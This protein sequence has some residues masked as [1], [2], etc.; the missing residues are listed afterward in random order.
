MV[1]VKAEAYLKGYSLEAL[2]DL[3][4]VPLTTP[5]AQNGYYINDSLNRLFSLVD[6]GHQPQQYAFE[7]ENSVP[8]AGYD[9]YGFRVQ[10]LHSPLFNRQSTPLLSSVRFR[11]HVLQEVIQLLSLSKEKPG[12]RYQR[13]RISYAQLGINQLG[14]V[15]EALLS[16]SGFFASERLYEVKPADAR[17]ADET[18]QTY[19]IPE[20]ELGRYE[21][22]EFV[23]DSATMQRKTYEKGS[24][25]FRLAGRDRQ[26]SASYYTPEVLTQCVVKYSLKELLKDK[27]ADDILRLTICEPAMGSG[28]FINEALN[29]LADA[30]LE[31]KQAETGQ[32]IA[33]DDYRLERQKV[34]Y[35]LAVNN[36]YGV[37]LNPTAVRL[38]EVSL[39]L[40]IL[41]PEAPTPWLGARLSAGN[42]LVGA[43]RQ[44]Y[45]SEEVKSGAYASQAPAPCPLAPETPEERHAGRIRP[46]PAGT[47]YHWLLPDAGMAAFDKDKVIKDL[48]PKEVEGIKTWRKEFTRPFSAAEIRNLVAL[49]DRADEL[50]QQALDERSQ[51]LEKTRQPV[52]V[53]RQPQEPAPAKLSIDQ[54]QKEL[55][56][57]QRPNGPYARLKLV[58]DYWCALWFWPIPEAT[59]LPTRKQYMDDLANIFAAGD[60]SGFERP[61]EQL[62]LFETP[63]LKQTRFGDIKSFT[64]NDLIR[65]NLRL[66]K[67]YQVANKHFFHHWELIFP[68]V[69]AKRDGFNLILGNP[70]W[71]KL[72][73]D[74]SSVLADFEPVVAIRK[75]SASEVA[76][77]R[78]R[79]LSK[80]GVLGE[81]FIQFV[82]TVASMEFLNADANYALLKGM[83]SNSYKCFVCR[84][85][86][87]GSSNGV[88]GFLHPE[89]VYEDSKGGS[90]R[91]QIYRR[92]VAHYLFQNQ[93][94]LF[95]DIGDRVRYSINIYKSTPKNDIK[96]DHAVNL[97]HPTT[98]DACY[99]HDGYGETPGIKNISGNW[100]VRG[101]KNRIVNITESNLDLLS[102][103]FEES[104]MPKIHTRL[105]LIHSNEIMHV[106]KKFSQQTRHLT[107][108]SNNY[109]A[110]EMWH[111][112]GAQ[113]DGTI[114]RD[115]RIP[116]SLD[117]WIVSGPHIYVATPFSKSPNEGCTSKGDYQEIDLI[118]IPDDFL[119]RTV[120][121]PHCPREE[122]QRRVPNWKQGKVTENY[123]HLHRY[124][125]SQAGER[126]LV[127][128]IAPPK[129]ANINTLFSISFVS[130]ALLVGFSG[131]CSSVIYDF[132]VKISG[133]GGMGNDLLSLLP[134]PNSIDKNNL[135]ISRTLR[136]NCLTFHYSALWE[137]L[138]VP[139]FN[140]DD[141]SR[142]DPRLKPWGDLTPH[143]QRHV[144]LRTPFERRQAL[145]EIDVLAALA[146]G[147]TLD[148]LLTIYRIQFPVLQEHEHALRFDQQGMEVPMKTVG[149]ELDVNESHPKFPEMVPP[150]TPV[151]REDDYRVAWKFFE[152]RLAKEPSKFW[153]P[154][155]N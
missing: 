13:G 146:L 61:P 98:I 115:C 35:F 2:R 145:V 126:T 99:S 33:P 121:A 7:M 29:Q 137:E 39:W 52:T 109:F 9:D 6:E 32:R 70:P 40:N 4:Q 87:V 134:I 67:V 148:E 23:Y 106:L 114:R 78:N 11:N 96:F 88:I 120:Y 44:V 38:A 79:L 92:L 26:K 50:W 95:S 45:T 18:A 80:Q 73:W 46:R 139:N 75:L 1:P 58:L 22:E 100:D 14:A 150:F 55:E 143:W 130:N 105:P 85:W 131:M 5:Q 127:N 132:F 107:D 97:F 103:V 43:R 60:D 141:W 12:R 89:G 47:I 36:A 56:K 24:F 77:Q 124:M 81:Y 119:P 125:L 76:N 30:Y 117:E 113:K 48:A 27:T 84:S 42:S 83:Q 62:G 129:A 71:V 136:L 144:A 69:F 68:D 153:K 118:N 112:T 41:Y 154:T 133:K 37:D 128:C 123:R 140:D 94:K 54:R 15:Y 116:V 152:E 142:V 122:Y 57:L 59:K 49:S 53:W 19:F 17:E 21:P 63:K 108:E 74:E 31:R 16:Y 10:G 147:L 151:D 64:I 82:E 25:V 34:K 86:D 155:W 8:V 51:F 28:A 91:A 102:Q 110:C 149:G 65:N 90:F 138:Y 101:H 3:E 93:L 104:G 66:E 20:S 111:E 135:L 72:G